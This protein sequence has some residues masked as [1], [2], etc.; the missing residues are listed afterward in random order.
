MDIQEILVYIAVGIAFAFLISKFVWKKKSK[1]NCGTD[2][3]CGS[4]H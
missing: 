4:C 1:K 2:E 3:N